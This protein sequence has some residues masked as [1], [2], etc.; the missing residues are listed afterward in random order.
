M[1]IPS[2]FAPRL[3]R[4]SLSASFG[5]LLLLQASISTADEVVWP[6]ATETTAG[7]SATCIP[8]TGCDNIA[9]YQQVFDS[10]QFS[11]IG[12]VNITGMRFRPDEGK[13][14][15]LSHQITNAEIN[16]GTT[17][18]G[19]LGLGND[20]AANFNGSGPVTVYGTAS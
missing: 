20:F 17:V 10:N 3:T 8:L 14:P 2:A 6:N 18:N 13:W 5:F 7:N 1:T 19:P 11:G 16:L 12:V 4:T 15:F 9:R